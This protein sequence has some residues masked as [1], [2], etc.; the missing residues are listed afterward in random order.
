MITEVGGRR[1]LKCNLSN[2]SSESETPPTPELIASCFTIVSE[3]MESRYRKSTNLPWNPAKLRSDL[4]DPATRFIVLLDPNNP[5]TIAAFTAYQ[6][7]SENDINN[8]PV[9][10]LY[11]YELHVVRSYRGLQ[12][13]SFLMSE[14]EALA[15]LHSK[16]AHKLMLT[17][18]KSLP[19]GSGYFKS[20]IDFYRKLGYASDPI[21]PSQCLGR[22]EALLYDYEIM[23]KSINVKK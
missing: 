18:F 16:D 6:F 12:L 21:S 17:A 9:P 11:C 7:T 20:P 23:S 22:K 5:K 13:G 2:V 8:T 10:V 1:F 19:R 4:N 15:S 3:H 14:L